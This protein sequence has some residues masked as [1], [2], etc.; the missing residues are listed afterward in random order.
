MEKKAF[1]SV[2]FAAQGIICATWIIILFISVDLDSVG[3][4]F[5]GGVVFGLIANAI[6]AYMCYLVNAKTDRNTTEASGIL[7][8]ISVGYLFLATILNSV[9]AIKQEGEHDKFLIILNLVLTAGY[10]IGMMSAGS[11]VERIRQQVELSIEK[12]TNTNQISMQLGKLLG[13]VSEQSLRAKI[14]SL[15][16]KVDYSTNVSNSNA[17]YNENNIIYALQEVELLV[18]NMNYDEA[19]KKIAQIEIMWNERNSISNTVR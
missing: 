1:S 6:S 9:Y 14:Y 2:Y 13:I 4:Y 3:F 17:V 7:T 16:E 11:N 10:V 15:K 12:T 19:D 18:M 8:V 5:W